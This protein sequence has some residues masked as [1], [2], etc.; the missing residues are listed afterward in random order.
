MPRSA[1][2]SLS[3]LT[4]VAL[5]STLVVAAG[6]RTEEVR[7]VSSG[8]VTLAGT[9]FL[10][11]GDG[12]FPVVVFTHGSEPGR[13]SMPGYTRWAKR[14]GKQGIAGLAFDKR[15]VGDSEGEYVEAPDLT[16]PAG[17]VLAWV[18]LLKERDDIRA[19][20]IGVLGWSQGG[21]VGPLAA[22][23][24]DDLAFVVSIS[25][26]GVSPLEQNIFDKT[27]QC[28]A[29]GAT[30]EQTAQFS[31]TIRLV[32][33]YLVVGSGRDDAQAAWDAVKDEAW[34]EKAYNGAPMMD[35]D[36]VLQH[37]RMKSYVA[38]SS[39]EPVPTL[40]KLRV[41]MLAVFGGA[42][43]IVPVEAS[44]EAMRGAFKVGGNPDFTYKVFPGAGHGIRV[45]GAPAAGF[46]EFVV[47]WIVEQ[48]GDRRAPGDREG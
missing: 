29:G 39:Y 7:V 38:H 16:V 17:D 25:G 9:L 48:V 44:I 19:D 33:T 21:W 31:R 42:D 18:G 6:P 41:P 36:A 2:R 46:S 43:A 13:R 26:P 27:N 12:P 30:A 15:G 40:Q 5:A 28:R 37:P 8:D 45:A 11:A 10:P 24:S 14:L 34:F 35:R 23:L 1:G 4:L 32:W 3:V 20:R 22:S 47:N